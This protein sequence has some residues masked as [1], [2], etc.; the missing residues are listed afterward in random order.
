[1]VESYL[2][3]SF[4]YWFYLLCCEPIMNSLLVY[5][6]I[7]F[8]DKVR[9]EIPYDNMEACLIAEQLIDKEPQ[10]LIYTKKG[11]DSIA[12]RCVELY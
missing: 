5:L 1:M 4:S 12:Y 11:I 8:N 10:R 9:I 3:Y 2:S 6:I 7:V